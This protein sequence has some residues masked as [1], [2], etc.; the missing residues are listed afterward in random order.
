[1][2]FVCS[3]NCSVKRRAV[4]DG[5]RDGGRGEGVGENDGESFFT[6]SFVTFCAVSKIRSQSSFGI[7]EP[8]EIEDQGDGA[9]VRTTVSGV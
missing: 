2:N 6:T 4:S 7:G 9:G 8:E 3:Y 1:M 5:E